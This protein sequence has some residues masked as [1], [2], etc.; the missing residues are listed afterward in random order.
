M[1]E[2]K[3]RSTSTRSGHR[4]SHLAAKPIKLA[5]CAKCGEPIIPHRVCKVCGTYKGKDILELARYEKEK[6]ERRKAAEAEEQAK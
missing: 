3:K 5:K 2:P 1:A 6:A 4:R